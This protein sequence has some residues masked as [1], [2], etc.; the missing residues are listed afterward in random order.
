[1]GGPFKPAF[2]LSGTVHIPNSV[3]PTAA[4]Y[5]AIGDLR[6]SDRRGNA[7]LGGH[8]FSRAATITHR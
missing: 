4:Y 5:R 3:I 7:E 2:G 8:G 1:M 6:I